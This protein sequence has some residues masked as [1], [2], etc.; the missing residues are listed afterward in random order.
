MASLSEFRQVW[1]C[2]FEFRQPNG[3]RPTPICMV[4]R[5]WRTG[6]T[7]C[8]WQHQL[9]DLSKAPFPTGPECVFIAFFASAELGCFLSLSWPMPA[10]ILD[11]YAE[12]RCLTS[13]LTVPCGY[14]LLGALIYFGMD[15]IAA[16]DKDSMRALAL[17]GDPY[18]IDERQALLDYCKCDVE[19]LT[20]LLP[21]ILP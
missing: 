20:K 14:G 21:A 16:A 19:A 10:R 3:E 13:G 4:A 2:D 12:F 7:V 11:L 1:F 18:T 8:L 9:W 6:Q 15:G 17:R 5:E